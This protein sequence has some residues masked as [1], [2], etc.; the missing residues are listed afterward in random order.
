MASA[1]K[2]SVTRANVNASFLRMYCAK[3]AEHADLLGIGIKRL[4]DDGN[5]CAKGRLFFLP[6]R[7]LLGRTAFLLRDLV[8]LP[9]ILAFCLLIKENLIVCRMYHTHLFGCFVHIFQIHIGLNF[10]LQQ[11]IV[12]F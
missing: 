2:A 1:N 6:A 9:Y 4:Q 10:P 8:I 5:H 11:I 7:F 3:A 12:S